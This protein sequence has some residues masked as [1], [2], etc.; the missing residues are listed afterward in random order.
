MNA[1]QLRYAIGKIDERFLEEAEHYEPE[2]RSRKP[3]WMIT[4]ASAAVIALC[5]CIYYHNEANRIKQPEIN[6]SYVVTTD[7]T[8]K[9]QE[10]EISDTV[11]C[12]DDIADIAHVNTEVSKIKSDGNVQYIVTIPEKSEPHSES[13]GSYSERSVITPESFENNPDSLESNTEFNCS[14]EVAENLETESQAEKTVIA[15]PDNYIITEEETISSSPVTSEITVP[16]SSDISSTISNK[17]DV[18]DFPFILKDNEGHKYYRQQIVDKNQTENFIQNRILYDPDDN[19]YE[20]SEYYFKD[21]ID[22]N[23]LVI[24]FEK[25]NSYVIYLNVNNG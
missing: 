21:N 5:T 7:Y 13:E 22:E 4:S 9:V 14:T 8:E 10:T 20:V 19:E 12:T 17:F 3:I 6:N 11:P 15:S 18:R 2:T 1:E 25:K 24:Y 23:I 16:Q